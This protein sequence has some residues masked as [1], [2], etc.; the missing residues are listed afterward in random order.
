MPVGVPLCTLLY[1]SYGN[2][3]MDEEALQVE[4]SYLRYFS[5][6]FQPSPSENTPNRYAKYMFSRKN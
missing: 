2:L 4:H 1:L 3:L 6:Q 5:A